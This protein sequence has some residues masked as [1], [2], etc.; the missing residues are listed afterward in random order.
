MSDEPRSERFRVRATTPLRRETL[1]RPDP[2][3]GLVAMNGPGD[4]EPSLVI[5]DGVVSELDGKP[6]E[7]FDTLDRFIAADRT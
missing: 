1:I 7:R 5:T 6:R 3:L 4:P 2:S